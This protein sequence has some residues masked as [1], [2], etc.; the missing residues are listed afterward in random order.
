[1]MKLTSPEF[2]DGGTIAARHAM[3][4]V[5]GG[6]NV[7]IAYDWS[8]APAQ[9]RSFALALVDRSPVAHDWVHRLVVDITPQT[10]ALPEGVSGSSAM[11]VGA[12]ELA[13]TYG[14][15]GYQGPQP[16][17]GSGQHLYEATIYALDTTSAAAVLAFE[18]MRQRRATSP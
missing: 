17:P 15:I 11:P 12:R 14:A 8:G 18:I 16:P 6:D 9:T 1:M 2:A 4:A 3:R 7:S 13:T 10:S 5:A